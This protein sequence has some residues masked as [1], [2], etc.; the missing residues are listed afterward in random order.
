M[1]TPFLS[2]LQT[3]VFYPPSLL[4]IV[5]F[6]LGFNLF[7]LA[8]YLVA[9]AGAY[10]FLRD[11]ELSLPASAIGSLSFVLGGYLV[12]MLNLTNHLQ[13]AVWAPWIVFCWVRH[14]RSG[15]LLALA[16][17]VCAVS[18]QLLGGSPETLAMTLA[19]VGGWAVYEAIP[20]GLVAVR[21]VLVL[22]AALVLVTA[23]TAFQILPTAELIRQSV[24]GHALSFYEASFWSLQPISILQLLFPHSTSLVTPEEKNTLGQVIEAGMPWI[25]SIY[26]GLIPLCLAVVGLT[27]G[28]ER[29]FWGSVVAAAMVMALGSYTPIFRVLY[30]LAPTILGKFRY[31]EKFY[32]LVHLASMVLAAEG[33]E[34]IIRGDRAAQR[35]ACI[36]AGLFL[37]VAGSIWWLSSVRPFALLSL[38]AHLDGRYFPLMAF[39]GIATD[40]VFKSQRLVLILGSFVAIVLLSRWSLIQTTLASV[41][42][43]AL[44][45]GDLALTHHNL[46]LSISWADLKGRPLLIDAAT[47]EKDRLRIFN[48]QTTARA[49]RGAEPKPVQ[50]LEES[51]KLISNLDNMTAV[52]MELWPTL[53]SNTAMVYEVRNI[54]GGEG[55]E[56]NS[57]SMFRDVLAMVPREKAIGL[58]RLYGVGY[59]IGEQALDLLDLEAAPP[60]SASPYHVYKTRDPIPLAYAVTR[61]RPADSDLKAFNFLISPGFKAG[62]EAVVEH[63]PEG[64]TDSP[65]NGSPGEVSIES[66]ETDR[67]VVRV[68]LDQPSLVVLNDSYYPGWEAEV[69]D[70]P[71]KIV[72]TN[73]LVRG[74]SVGS[75]SHRV[76][77]DYRPASFRI[78]ARISTIGIVV[79]TG[80]TVAGICRYRRRK[81]ID[82]K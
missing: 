7:L 50:G 64:W 21:S 80:L 23:V 55:I 40:F 66:Y 10:V 58:L 33:A 1:G 5:P 47:L 3:G 39:V 76:E 75:G 34:K 81:S 41:L 60:A 53:S 8:H 56:R 6:P 61:L 74:V 79:L 18:L 38:V 73:V 35:M 72:R 31:P 46:N 16:G 71:A 2:S 27:F 17:F 77:F 42:L 49:Q 26:L 62:R 12:S 19:L 59:L 82:R 65:R 43:A 24:R 29:R 11:R 63:L 51:L 9:L 15:S 68:N 78:G 22:S 28:R 20:D 69:D 36:V 13:S 30:D 70:R 44:T 45:A 52:A 54:M 4:L 37:F 25:N 32:F 67:V 14:Q 57:V 48:Y